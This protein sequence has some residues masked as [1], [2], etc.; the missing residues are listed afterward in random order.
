MLQELLSKCSPAPQ[1]KKIEW[2][3]IYAHNADKEAGADCEERR[4]SIMQELRKEPES[5]A[6]YPEKVRD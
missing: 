5:A 2:A 6:A 4:E 3:K 1:K